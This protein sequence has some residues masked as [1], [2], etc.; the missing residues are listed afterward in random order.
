MASVDIFLSTRTLYHQLMLSD[1]ELGGETVFPFL[2]L[3]V[4]AQKGSLVVWYNLFLN[5]TSDWRVVHIS[6]PI[7]MGDKWIATKWLREYPQ[8]FIR[9]CPL[10]ME[11]LPEYSGNTF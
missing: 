8:M 4:P 6:C 1:V 7:L 5:G 2:D 11:P 9:P 3:R 10:K